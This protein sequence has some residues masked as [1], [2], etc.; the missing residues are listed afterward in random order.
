MRGGLLLP[1]AMPPRTA[2]AASSRPAR[3]L[4]G[5]APLDLLLALLHPPETRPAA[6]RSWAQAQ[7]LEGDDANDLVTSAEASRDRLLEQG[8]RAAYARAEAAEAAEHWA[9][10]A[11]ARLRR[12][13]GQAA[14]DVRA[15][16][17]VCFEAK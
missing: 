12:T 11:E 3:L 4:R 10:D 6:L 1:H 17:E 5:V 9:L 8:V 13:V 7:G 2:A 16:Y 14:A 15:V